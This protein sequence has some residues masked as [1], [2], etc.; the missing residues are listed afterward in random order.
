MP[1]PYVL[2]IQVR[3]YTRMT[4]T[5]SNHTYIILRD[6]GAPGELCAGSAETLY[7][8]PFAAEQAWRLSAGSI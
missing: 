1:S 5:Y 7:D 2:Q 8:A 4:C 6:S 3:Q